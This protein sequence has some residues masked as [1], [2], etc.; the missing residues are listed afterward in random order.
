MTD[1]QIVKWWQDEI[2]LAEHV[3]S[4]YRDGIKVDIIRRT[5]DLI[6]RQ[7]ATIDELTKAYRSLKSEKNAEIE[8]LKADEEMAEGYADALI[9]RTKIEAIKEFWK[10]LREKAYKIHGFEVIDVEDSD[11]LAKEMVG[12]EC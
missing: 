8:R 5:L 10:R 6:N 9:E 7:K 11:N 12:D 1:E 4:D 2:R 3:D